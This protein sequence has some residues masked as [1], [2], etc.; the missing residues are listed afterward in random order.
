MP[1]TPRFD[2]YAEKIRA[3]FAKQ[4]M[5]GTLGAE[6]RVAPGDGGGEFGRNVALSASG[7]VLAVAAHWADSGDGA[8]YVFDVTSS[9]ATQVAKVGAPVAGR[10]HTVPGG[11]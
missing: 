10:G 2:G 8:V 5:M 11:R 1:A 6:L 3:S 9:S 4:S 7:T